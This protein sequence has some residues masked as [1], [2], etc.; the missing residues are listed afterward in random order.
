MKKKIDSLFFRRRAMGV[1]SHRPPLQESAPAAAFHPFSYG[2]HGSALPYL[3]QM[4]AQQHSPTAGSAGSQINPDRQINSHANQKPT[5]PNQKMKSTV[6]LG[7]E[8]TAVR[9]LT[10]PTFF[11]WS[12]SST[13]VWHDLPSDR[14]ANH[15]VHSVKALCPRCLGGRNSRLFMEW[16]AS[17]RVKMSASFILSFQKSCL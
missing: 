15:F 7:F 5:E 13:R 9:G 4:A 2:V 6:D 12:R 17:L 1:G 11:R 14:M 8:G 10:R 3:F 16:D